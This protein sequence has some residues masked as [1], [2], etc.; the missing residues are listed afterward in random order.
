MNRIKQRIIAVATSA[1]MLCSLLPNV[2]M[3]GTTFAADTLPASYV[4]QTMLTVEDQGETNLC[5]AFATASAMEYNILKNQSKYTTEQLAAMTQDGEIDLY[6]KN[7]AYYKHNPYATS[8]SDPTYVSGGTNR[9]HVESVYQDGGN[10][11]V[12]A[13]QLARWS[14]PV[15]SSTETDYFMESVM[16]VD[17]ATEFD[18]YDSVAHL[19]NTIVIGR[20]DA[21]LESKVKQAILDYGAVTSAITVNSNYYNTA[22]SVATDEFYAYYYPTNP[23]LGGTGIGHG[24]AIVGW[25]DNYSKDN[26]RDDCKPAS[27]GAWLCR[28]S[29]SASSYFWL[30]YET[31]VV[32][33][34]KF[35]ENLTAF[36]VEPTDNYDNIY[37]YSG[38]EGA[39]KNSTANT[40]AVNVFTAENDEVLEAVSF[41]VDTLAGKEAT[42]YIKIWK[43]FTAFDKVGNT[44]LT[45]VTL[46]TPDYEAT[47]QTDKFYT[48]VEI[49]PMTLKQGEKYA[50]SVRTDLGARFRYVVDNGNASLGRSYFLVDGS[51]A[52]DTY[53]GSAPATKSVPYG[54]Q[55]Y[56][57]Y[58]GGNF[59]IRAF[60]SAIDKYTVTDS[61]NG[62]H[63]LER[64]GRFPRS[65]SEEH[66][67]SL[68]EKDETN[69]TESCSVCDYSADAVHTFE[70]TDNED[71]TTH[72][73]TCECGYSVTDEEHDLAY[74]DNTNG[75]HSISCENCDYTSIGEHDV[76]Y[77]NKDADKHTVSCDNECGY[78]EDVAHDFAYT[79]NNDGTH[80]KS[81]EKECGFTAVTEECTYENGACKFCEAEANGVAYIDPTADVKENYCETYT[82]FTSDMTVLNAGWYYV[83]GT[84]NLNSAIT[85][86]GDVKLILADGCSLT[87]PSVIVNTGNSLTVYG[88]KNGTGTLTATG[89]DVNAGIGSS[90]GNAG[91]DITINGGTI[92]ATGG[93][94]AAGIGGAS[95]RTSGTIIINGGNITATGGTGT[96]GAPGIGGGGNA[97][98]GAITIN[99]GNIKAY[100]AT[101]TYGDGWGA[102]AIG[103]G[104]MAGNC[105][106]IIING[107][108]QI[109]AVAVGDRK[110]FGTYDGA[111]TFTVTV[112]EGLSIYNGIGESKT[113]ADSVT[114]LSSVTITGSHQG[115]TATC[116]DK[117]ICVACGKKYGELST[118]NHTNKAT[119]WSTDETHH[120]YACSDCNG[121]ADKAEHISGGAATATTPETCS[122]CGYVISPATGAFVIAEA[123]VELSTTTFTYNG[124][125]QKPTV[126]V[127]KG[128]T[129][130]VENTDYTLT[131]TADST[132]AGAKSVTVTGTGDYSGEVELNYT[133]ERAVIDSLAFDVTAPV[134]GEVPEDTID[135]AQGGGY[136]AAIVWTPEADTFGYD[137]AYTATVTFTADANHIFANAL[138]VQNWTVTLGTDSTTATA[139]RT[140]GKTEKAN[141][142]YSV[143]VAKTAI[144]NGTAQAL[145][146]AGTVTGGTM[147]YALSEDGT[148]TA[149]IP[150]GT[151]AGDYT[152]WYYVKGADGFNDTA[153][154]NVEV[155]IDKADVTITAK[156]YTIKVGDTLPTYAYDVAG[157]VNGETLPIDV[158][159]SCNAADSNT[160]GTYTITVSGAANSTNYTFAYVNGT[161]TI[162]NKLEQTIT[163]SDVTLTYG[164]TGKKITATSN[165]NGAISYST[166]SDVISVAADG[167]I[168]A[169]KAGT[170]TVTVK[171]AETDNY[172]EATKTVTV[173]VNKAAV[174]VTAN[175]YTIKVGEALPTY[176]YD[177]T[178]LVNGDTLPFNVSLSCSATDSNTVGIYPI[179][180]SGVASDAL[181]SLYTPIY[182]NGELTITEKNVQTITA[183]DVTLTYGDTAKINATTNGDGTISYTVATGTDVITVAADGTVTPLKAGTA[184]VTI[185]AADTADYAVATKTVTVTVNKKKIAIP[186]ADTKEYTYTGTAQTYGVA[187]TDDYTVTGGVQTNAGNYPITIALK[188]ENYE[189]DGTLGTYTFV[190]KQ[191]N[192]TI[193][194]KSYTIKVGEALPT[195]EYDV[196][197]LV[198]GET[199]PIDV[200]ISC[201]ATN[202]ET[203]GNYPITVTGVADS[204]NYKFTYVNGT[205]TVSA[206]EEQTITASNVT[207]TYGDTAKINATTNGNGA[208]S[209]AVATGTDVITV[210]ADGTVTPLKAGTATVTI[211][212][213][214]TDTYAQATK[215]VTITVNKATVTIT[216][217]D[218]TIYIGEDVPAFEYTATGLV[219]GET[220]PI[221]PVI[222]CDVT[223]TSKTGTYDIIVT[224]DA[225]SDNYKFAYVNGTL[226]VKRKSTGGGGGGGGYTPSRPSTPT[227]PE[228]GGKAKT[229]T[230]IATEL[231]GMANGSETTI[232]LNGNYDVPVDVIKAIAEKDLKVTFIVDTNRSWYVDGADITNP[233]AADLSVTTT[234]RVDSSSLRGIEG[235]E[236]SIDGTSLPTEFAYSFAKRNA[237][238][239]ANLYIKTDD[240]FVFVDN[241]K[242][243]ENG[244]AKELDLSVKGQYVIM[245]CEFSDRMGDSNN[246]GVLNAMDASAILRDIVELEKAANPEMADY[247]G[248]GRT[249]A[250]DA[251][252]I[253]KV[254]VGLIPDKYE[255]KAENN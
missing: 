84:F 71:G 133:I 101:S 222:T 171:A 238:K 159:I 237:G 96:Y 170:A 141:P 123:D 229:W 60:T 21:G 247:N 42:C 154:A 24:I 9:G 72:T 186:A 102:A 12:L 112:G 201:S 86:S 77:V 97:G 147:M 76:S 65:S 122:V 207:T 55:S 61:G 28:N 88:Q 153:K 220:L 251:S 29:R 219:N 148:Y 45:D 144:Y 75:T 127:T 53:T 248:D 185:T 180:I 213:A 150:T 142:T 46:P 221:T 54:N 244:L 131:F 79:P 250:L 210:A 155:N 85:V 33:G 194:A 43:D 92:F 209:Y 151:N 47:V 176:A 73:A 214:E 2:G 140:F 19:Q 146:T 246:D 82:E 189:W 240:G 212:A 10:S 57:G 106:S 50:V 200:T 38:G 59:H 93:G 103:G 32:G 87:T 139:T 172:A 143:P 25:D 156:N 234:I 125:A 15:S 232:E 11:L 205:L 255:F 69:H 67:L 136:S 23:T 107:A 135:I 197:G 242:L 99:G 81:C 116:V 145:V 218:Y 243:D 113:E 182:V 228:I 204:T 124:N 236:F 249:N 66:I 119:E 168:T 245:V 35:L 226:T 41:F 51:N 6:E 202:S 203:E 104:T 34:Y 188:D 169:L 120:W 62:S 94:Q 90:N 52:I 252:E 158:T 30:S 233:V 137:T 3:G 161:L 1:V 83:D 22:P 165:G 183:S 181:A 27:D 241:V 40:A 160:A 184:T 253:L 4:P 8:T 74:T 18:R 132:N 114:G 198:N 17:P 149:E 177:V 13:W 31:V 7:L 44:V 179:T 63:S 100:G 121:E 193:T 157:L 163:A 227:N 16:G 231:N 80:Q 199:L 235:Y 211:T 162:S 49:P 130:L 109:E 78:T 206:K 26:F 91:G 115:G 118:T 191:A 134:A 70:Y 36:G 152:V 108:C 37:Q 48:T 217:K 192:V 239:F 111:G 195:F 95:A 68:A 215:T 254:I 173:T 5:W 58:F 223:D 129:T 110:A 174:T 225:E 196:T 20:E 117:A 178:G 89:N 175:S 230:D 187:S 14:G 224:G 98:N 190:I 166:T 105:G 56:S 167:T 128:E 208:I 126:T 138:S 216:A 39:L 164:E 64:T